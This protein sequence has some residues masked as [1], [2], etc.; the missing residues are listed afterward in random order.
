VHYSAFNSAFLQPAVAKTYGVSRSRYQGVVSISL[1]KHGDEANP[2]SHGAFITG[3]AVNLSSQEKSLKFT[4]VKEGD[5]IYYISTF[6]Y[7]NNEHLR[8]EIQVTPEGDERP[9]NLT[10]K[11]WFYVD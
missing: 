11:Q 4:E 6:P 3:K 2:K 8:F 10:F 1:M 5:A 7:V 9:H